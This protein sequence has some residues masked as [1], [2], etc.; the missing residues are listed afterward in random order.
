MKF[1]IISTSGKKYLEE[2][3]KLETI[4]TSGV[5]QKYEIA[6]FLSNGSLV[7]S[8][9]GDP[10]FEKFW[11]DYVQDLKQ[12]D[13]IRELI[14]SEDYI[15]YEWNRDVYYLEVDSL[16]QLMQYLERLHCEIIIQDDQR[17]GHPILEVYDTYRD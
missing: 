11:S 2:F 5:K 6:H 1:E 7:S 15:S 16:E 3:V 12:R 14:V 17:D 13:N 4:W 10:V 8:R 9:R